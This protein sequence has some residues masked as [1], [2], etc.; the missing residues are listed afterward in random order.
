MTAKKKPALDDLLDAFIEQNAPRCSIATLITGLP[1][2][3][4]ASVNRLLELVATTNRRIKIPA[5]NAATMLNAA[6]DCE[7]VGSA[8]LA[9]NGERCTCYGPTR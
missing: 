5:K 4:Q 7:V 9:H 1:E 3:D 2:D 6:F 8:I